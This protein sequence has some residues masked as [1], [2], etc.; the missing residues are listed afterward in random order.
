MDTPDY[1]PQLDTPPLDDD[2]LQALD[3][4]LQALP[5]DAVMNI[6]ALDGYLTAL[7]VGP[8]VLARQRTAAWMPAIW[9]GDTGAP[10]SPAPFPSQ[11]QRKRVT[12]LVLRHLHAIQRQLQGPPEAW[13]PI[14]SVAE[15][16]GREWVDAEDWCAGFLAATVL[17]ADA[18]GA[19]FDD[20]ELG[21]LLV[22]VALLGGDEAALSPADQARLADPDQRDGL[23][24]AV[25]DAVL[26]LQARRA[27]PA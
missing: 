21:P 23:S 19:L 5:G 25:V 1:D 13:E 26:A 15:A 20:A 18:W 6:E 4:L 8:P 10:G 27:G 2:E 7:M 14:F 3:A 12:L 22:P 17:D 24:R 16:E 11:K 9:G